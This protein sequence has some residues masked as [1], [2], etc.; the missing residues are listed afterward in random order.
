[1]SC[2]MK[3]IFMLAMAILMI[4]AS[5]SRAQINV[6]MPDIVA[7]QGTEISYPVLISNVSGLNLISY[8]IEL[9]Y[10]SEV[11]AATGVTN[12]NTISEGWDNLFYNLSIPDELSIAAFSTN[13][14]VGEGVLVYINFQVSG[15]P[16][17]VSQM[18][19]QFVELSGDTENIVKQ[20]GRIKVNSNSV[21][22][23]IGT[24]IPI[25]STVMVD[26]VSYESPYVTEW[27]RGSNH[28]IKAVDD[29]TTPE[30]VRYLFN[31]WSDG[32]AQTHVVSTQVDT[33]FT[34]HYAMQYY[35]LLESAHGE[36]TGEGWYDAGATANFSVD[37]EVI[38]SGDTKYRFDGWHSNSP[39]GYNGQIRNATVVMSNPITETVTWKPTYLIDI[40]SE[41]GSTFGSGWYKEGEIVRCGINANVIEEEDARYYFQGWQGV[42]NGSYSGS[43]LS[44]NIIV[45][46]PLVEQAIWE[47]WYFIE[48]VSEP[49]GL[50][51]FE[52]SGWYASGEMVTSD[53]APDTVIVGRVEYYFKGWRLNGIN[54]R[55]N[56]TFVT[57]DSAMKVVASYGYPI[58]VMV[59]TNIGTGTK[60]IVDG[61][62]YDVPYE[63][64][65]MAY[66]EHI[67]G[68][69]EF[70]TRKEGQRFAFTAWN[71]GGIR[72]QTV[73]PTTNKTYIAVLR[74]QYYLRVD[75]RPEGIYNL[76]GTDW[77]DAGQSVYL[78]PAPTLVQHGDQEFL[79]KYWSVN[80]NITHGNP[81]S[82]NINEPKSAFAHYDSCY[83]I[84]GTIYLDGLGLGGIPI[85]LTGLKS[86]SVYS[87]RSGGY[88]F[89][90]LYPGNY[91]VMP[92]MPGYSFNPARRDIYYLKAN[93]EHQDFEAKL[94]AAVG[95]IVLQP[96][97]ATFTMNQNYPN[98][99][100]NTT[101]ISFHV[102]RE[103]YVTV[104]IVNTLGVTV[105]TLVSRT[106]VAGDYAQQ[107]DGL[108]DDRNPLASGL[109]F[110]T[111]K[112]E[113][114]VLTRKMIL[115]E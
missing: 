94:L 65:W 74:T 37:E 91:T 93:M 22:V 34:A 87:D 110:Y 69:P 106:M 114:I 103:S 85:V 14:L 50:V 92:R 47:S 51:V 99:F 115:M 1:M 33:S 38:V 5:L 84:S 105:R 104:T 53:V 28:I 41:H 18:T 21:Q 49:A 64:E 76:T 70:Q 46:N 107:W 75:T 102:P 17:A 90:G 57:A 80:D 12:A 83:S 71:V 27:I 67:I 81:I 45:R 96:A 61:V 78:D 108:D 35:L 79:F 15:V 25:G 60:V 6:T 32:K 40:R 97:P 24:D 111:L 9:G 101:V 10:D 13:P 30:G 31:S 2:L 7:D 89:S 73:E 63:A 98:P 88:K 112:A 43:E 62:E 20:N 100:N 26:G 4:G 23:V 109:Y 3:R 52:K 77:Y 72:E 42:G 8:Q 59:T 68:V 82:I 113:D 11:V 48:F 66:D 44:F 58:Q 86:D 56:P 39:N 54:L 95:E 19:F 55:G 29:V 16:G 36:P